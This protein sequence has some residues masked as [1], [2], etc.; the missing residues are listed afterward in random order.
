MYLLQTRTFGG[1]YFKAAT[2]LSLSILTWVAAAGLLTRLLMPQHFGDLHWDLFLLMLA[3]AFFGVWF[4]ETLS[5]RMSNE[6]GKR[7]FAVVLV[8][9]IL[10]FVVT[11][12]RRGPAE[13]EAP[14]R[15][16]Q[17]DAAPTVEETTEGGTVEAPAV[18]DVVLDEV[19]VTDDGVI[20]LEEDVQVVE[21][22]VEVAPVRPSFRDRLGKARTV[23]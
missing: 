20:V 18:D 16:P 2:A 14:P 12:R 8:L 11:S 13:L 19:I 6:G 15:R 9:G 1:Y 22:P 10:G 3:P 7:A 5:S 4:G 21:E 23:F 17:V